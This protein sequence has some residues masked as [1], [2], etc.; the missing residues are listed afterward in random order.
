MGLFD[1]FAQP[2][3]TK[4][5]KRYSTLGFSPFGRIDPN[6]IAYVREGYKQNVYV[7]RAARL[8]AQSVAACNL[9]L[10]RG[11]EDEPERF[12]EHAAA[13]VL[14]RPNPLQGH[15]SFIEALVINLVLHGQV[16]VERILGASTPR[17][18]YPVSGGA[19][20]AKTSKSADGFI[21]G[22]EALDA[23]ASWT[24]EEMHIIMLYDPDD[25]ASGFSPVAPAGEAVNSSNY[26]GRYTTGLLKANGVSP[27]SITVNGMAIENEEQEQQ[28]EKK[29]RDKVTT[30]GDRMRGEGTAES[31]FFQ[32]E[33]MMQ[34]LGF[35]PGEMKLL[36]MEQQSAREIAVALGPAPELLGDPENKVY[37][38]MV[39]ARKALYTEHAIPMANLIA[40]ELTT[41][42]LPQFS[43]S[44]RDDIRF[45]I[46]TEQIEALQP[47]PNEMR[48][49]D[50][51]EVR[52]GVITINEYRERRGMQPKRGG[53]VLMLP[54][55]NLPF[56]AE[57][58]E[59]LPEPTGD[60]SM[61]DEPVLDE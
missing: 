51:D 28:L 10:V 41:W 18:L 42:L 21:E 12:D 47:D 2:V 48:R 11:S 36:E 7:Y 29:W 54:S 16:F 34:R 50:L 6:R 55:S 43:T 35:S 32:G 20:K 38:N 27:H 58:E 1:I 19:V 44:D 45:E 26:A 33:V 8:M 15:T 59:T 49:L 14:R 37:N 61:D 13:K 25:P 60:G 17:E 4:Q 30:A 56:S 22:Y 46:D 57:D 31:I 24:P 39:E 3:E 23:S 52:A 40:D 53:D 5:S 9:H